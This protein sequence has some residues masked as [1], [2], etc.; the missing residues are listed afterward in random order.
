MT[1]RDHVEA[2]AYVAGWRF[3][4]AVPERSARRAFTAAADVMWRR[5]GRPVDQLAR[6]LARVAPQADLPALTRAG[7]R[8]YLRYWLEVFRLPA[9]TP[10]EIVSRMRVDGLDHLRGAL[11]GGRGV[12][13]ALPHMGNWDHAGAWAVLSG[14]APTTVAERLRPEALFDRF[15]EFRTS[16]GIEVVPLTGGERPPFPVLADRLR[17]G[18]LVCLLADRDLTARGVPVTFFGEPTRMPAGP[19]ALALE[20]GAALLPVTLWFTS[21]GTRA[22]VHPELAPP[23][24]ERAAQIRAMTQALADVFAAGIAEHPADWHMLQRL[25]LADLDPAARARVAE[26]SVVGEDVV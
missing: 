1:V 24:A 16:L 19:A 14:L 11:G 13:A 25:W 17:A 12:V 2:A 18:R 26:D 9:L 21:T 8:S 15:V 10:E 22:R 23:G 3:L 20:T 7:L 4:R 5:G 6:N